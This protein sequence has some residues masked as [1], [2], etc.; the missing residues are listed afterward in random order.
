MS[1]LICENA[2]GKPRY[3]TFELLS[4]NVVHLSCQERVFSEQYLDNNSV[5]F[6][7]LLI[8]KYRPVLL[9]IISFTFIN[10]ES[11]TSTGVWPVLYPPCTKFQ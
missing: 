9:I 1:S 3:L 8:D 10:N 11:I 5:S 7:L 2:D 4:E 6:E